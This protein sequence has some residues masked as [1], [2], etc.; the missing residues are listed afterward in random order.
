MRLKKLKPAE[1]FPPGEFIQ[2]EMDARGW[3]AAQLA[4]QSLLTEHAIQEILAGNWKITPFLATFLGKAFGVERAL[5]V[6]LQRTWDER[7][8]P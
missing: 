4:K 2:E 7:G 3:D 8:Q 5:F 1:V 6:N